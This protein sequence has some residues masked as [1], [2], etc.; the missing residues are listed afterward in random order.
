MAVRA[1]RYVVCSVHVVALAESNLRTL[2]Y[3]VP[4]VFGVVHI[5]DVSNIWRVGPEPHA[6]TDVDALP[7][8]PAYVAA[9]L[10]FRVVGTDATAPRAAVAASMSVYTTAENPEHAEGG[11]L[12]STDASAVALAF[13]PYLAAVD[14]NGSRDDVTAVFLAGADAC[15]ILTAVGRDV[16]TLDDN[17]VDAGSLSAADA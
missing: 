14:F 11:I 12:A 6:R 15:A 3:E 4:P 9:I 2:V 1:V 5:L 8:C 7:S 17:L 16:A 10:M 13:S